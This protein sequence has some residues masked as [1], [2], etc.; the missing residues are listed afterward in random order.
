MKDLINKKVELRIDEEDGNSY[1]SIPC[2]IVD[3]H[4]ETFRFDDGVWNENMIFYVN[5][6]PLDISIIDE[7]NVF[8]DDFNNVCLGDIFKL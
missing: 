4:L 8:S 3:F 1:I 5:L 2:K 6:E 7:V